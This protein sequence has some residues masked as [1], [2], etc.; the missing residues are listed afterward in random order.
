MHHQ[1]FGFVTANRS[2]AHID[3]QMAGYKPAQLEA[4]YRQLRDN[5]GAIPGVK[6]VS[7][8]LYSPME[9]DNWGEGVYIDGEPPP[10]P[11]TP[12]TGA[13]PLGA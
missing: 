11:G 4:M 12:P 6:Q 10:P 8:S 3:P 5:L 9:G 13:A 1:D 7:F 2:I